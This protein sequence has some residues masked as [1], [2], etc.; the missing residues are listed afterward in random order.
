MKK[1]IKLICLTTI[2][3]L[4]LVACGNK[5]LEKD[6]NLAE[7]QDKLDIVTTIFPAYDFT[8]EIG[9]DRVDLTM[10]VKPGSEIHSFDPT[11]QD[12]K[13]IQNCDLFIYNGG[14]S[15]VWV[16][17]ILASLDKEPKTIKMM[18]CVET[19]EEE[20]VEGM[21]VEE[22][23]HEHEDEVEVEVDEHIWTSPK[24]AIKIVEKIGKELEDIDK[25]NAKFY[26]ENT[27]EFV[28]QLKELDT[29]LEDIISS[30]K[31]RTIVFGDRFPFAYL[32]R[33]YGLD[34]FAAFNGCSTETDASPATV[35]FL[36]NKIND[37]QIPV[38]FN[39][40]MS[41]EKISDS[42]CDST[43]AK[44]LMLHSCQNVSADEFKNGETYISIMDKNLENIRE[45]LN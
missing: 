5:D 17:N 1:I 10:L 43:S 7:N 34:Y 11:P 38:V 23:D 13:K 3:S 27:I 32:A 22:H 35:A 25:E 20:I 18:D 6:E 36:V 4:F 42:I 40:E 12:I 24:N 37:N 14:E 39:I 2:T 28:T 41:N 15:D 30:A 8:R 45:A 16:D 26:A 44:K 9:K 19:M 29:R 31:R 33:D 21:Q